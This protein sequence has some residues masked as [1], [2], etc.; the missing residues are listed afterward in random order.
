M[1]IVGDG[2]LPLPLKNVFLSP[3]S[4]NLLSVGQLIHN[5]RNVLF[6]QSGCVVQDRV[7]GKVIVKGP[8]CGRLFP[9]HLSSNLHNKPEFAL[10]CAPSH[11]NWKL[12]HHRLGHPHSKILLSLFKTSLILKDIVY[13]HDV[14]MDCSTCKLQKKVRFFHWHFDFKMLW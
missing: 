3:L 5:D 2:S 10:L 11:N 1:T 7:S 6:S 12:W 14:L 13:F 9:L 4:V 8:K